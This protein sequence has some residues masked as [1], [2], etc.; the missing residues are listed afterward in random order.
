MIISR[1]FLLIKTD[2]VVFII[3][4]D[5]VR[6]VYVIAGI[7]FICIDIKP[8]VAYSNTFGTTF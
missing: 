5:V 7:Q 6:N 2:E 1:D 4:Q 8:S 3:G